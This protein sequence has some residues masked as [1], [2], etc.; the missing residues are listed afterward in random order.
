[1][2]YELPDVPAFSLDDSETEESHFISSALQVVKYLS[3]AFAEAQRLAYLDVDMNTVA[4]SN[5][6]AFID[7]ADD[8]AASPISYTIM[9]VRRD[10]PI[11]SSFNSVWMREVF[12]I[13]KG[14]HEI[15]LSQPNIRHPRHGDLS[16]VIL[17][18]M[19][20]QVGATPPS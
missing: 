15:A 11:F 8:L 20:F 6:V 1:M 7:R 4:S 13:V 17:G 12:A 9:N 18:G 19:C 5:F 2:S 3:L 16:S 14:I 10:K